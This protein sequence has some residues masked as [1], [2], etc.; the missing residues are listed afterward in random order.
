MQN[1]APKNQAC[2]WIA[3]GCGG[4]VLLAILVIGLL[5]W[6]GFQKVKT[7]QEELEDPEKRS[8]RVLEILGANELPSG[9]YPGL[10]LEIPFIADIAFVVDREVGDVENLSE[11]DF[12]EGN[13]FIFVRSRGKLGSQGKVSVGGGEIRIDEAD[14][15][16]QSRGIIAEGSLHLVDDDLTWETHRGT[17]EG[18]SQPSLLAMIRTR[19]PSKRNAIGIWFGPDPDPNLP[20][21][22]LDLSGT[23][24]DPAA[25]ASFLQH[26]D[27]CPND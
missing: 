26:F 18:Q 12:N 5:G 17:M 16:I 8:A 4:A 27:F 2:I 13:G 21:E 6:L 10:G 1:E 20:A 7:V 24:A 23:P 9:Y 25:I 14:L 19:C 3:V 22:S 11:V 15:D